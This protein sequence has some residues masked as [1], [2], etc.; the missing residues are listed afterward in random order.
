M[1]GRTICDGIDRDFIRQTIQ[2]SVNIY[3]WITQKHF[4]F[5]NFC[6]G[7]K[8]H[9]P[10]AT[11]CAHATP[12]HTIF[13]FFLYSFYRVALGIN[14]G[15]KIHSKNYKTRIIYMRCSMY[16]VHPPTC[17]W[18]KFK[19]VTYALFSYSRSLYNKSVN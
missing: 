6:V 5:S 12:L 2:T 7:Q 1:N 19:R 16:F 11:F 3:S 17:K 18:S 13:V 8:Q 4:P 10:E 14:F 15:W 9:S